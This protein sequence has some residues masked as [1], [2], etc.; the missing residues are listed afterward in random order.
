MIRTFKKKYR[1]FSGSQKRRVGK[2]SYR[3][4]IKCCF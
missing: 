4:Y 2:G 1:A 3:K